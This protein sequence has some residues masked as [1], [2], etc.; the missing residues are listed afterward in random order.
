MTI[1]VPRQCIVP[2]RL[3]RKMIEEGTPDQRR[4]AL[5]TLAM[6]GTFRLARAEHNARRTGPTTRISL[7]PAGRGSPSRSIYDQQNSSEPAL[8]ELVRSEGDPA[9]VDAAVN[10]AYDGFGATYRFFWEIFG[11]HSI[12]NQGM[13]LLGLVHFG[14]DYANAFWDGQGHM[15]FGDGDG[16]F[17]LRLTRSVDVIA[18]ELTHGVT[19]NETGL[20]YSSQSGALNESMSD[21]FASLVKQYL[22]SHDAASADWLIGADIV[23][24][25]LAPA[26]RSLKAPGKANKFDDQPASMDDFVVTTDDQGGVHTNSGIPNHAFYVVA[27]TLGG[28]AWEVA[29]RIWYAAL[30]DP[31]IRPNTG[32][33]SFARITL[34][35]AREIYGPTGAQADA[36]RAGW[37]KVKVP[38]G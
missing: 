14:R 31:Q 38:L 1:Q 37:D 13:A 18:H 33:R 32:F 2:P 21:V 11:R 35:Q 24:P 9:V 4:V 15:F 30:R 8:G 7:L 34:R 6:D 23:G 12:D 10:E 16:Q 19:Q 22:L 29:G 26:L 27:T 36:V 20:A 17:L 25:E 28:C 5:N 3:L